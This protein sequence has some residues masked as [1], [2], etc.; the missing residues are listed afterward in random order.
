MISTLSSFLRQSATNFKG[1]K[2]SPKIVVF[3]SDD[4]G[5]LRT[6]KASIDPLLH[7]FG[8]DKNKNPYLLYDHPASA[9]DVSALFDLLKLHKDALENSPVITANVNVANPDFEFI[10]KSNF[11]QYRAES[12]LQTFGRI[13]SETQNP[14]SVWKQG[15]SEGLF[16]PQF[17]GRE[18]LWVNAWLE[19]LQNREPLFL[20]AFEFGF[21]GITPEVYKSIS[22]NFQAAFDGS[23]QKQS[24]FVGQSIQEGVDLFESIFGFKP[25]TFI[26]TN[27]IWSDAYNSYLKQNGIVGVQG[28]KYQLLP[29]ENP[30]DAR[31]KSRRWN[32]QR[33]DGLVQTV[34]NA[35][36]EP[37]FYPKNQRKFEVEKCLSQINNAFLWNQPAI[38]STHRL[39]FSGE[40]DIENRDINLSLL[41]DL[42][43]QMLKKWPNILFLNSE[44]ITDLYLTKS[45]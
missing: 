13:F 29:K 15:I 2:L 4:W 44:Q 26:P 40:L 8:I 41:N 3:E 45:A 7:R 28:M 27:Y 33:R 38:I 6:P 39:N 18:H 36:F 11:E 37:A 30:T 42:L 24:H 31:A 10:K 23:V 5:S 1:E 20:E 43:R 12:M 19:T 25:K 32:G 14:I 35:T 9:S 22:V 21:W 34:R 16:Y 17:H